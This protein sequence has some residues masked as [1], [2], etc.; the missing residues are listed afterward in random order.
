MWERHQIKSED[1]GD[2]PSRRRCSNAARVALAVSSLVAVP[3][4]VAQEA[5][6][7]GNSGYGIQEGRDKPYGHSRD[8]NPW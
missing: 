3:P 5:V 6:L 2:R 8:R 7:E 4:V 1:A